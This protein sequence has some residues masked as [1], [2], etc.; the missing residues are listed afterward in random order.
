MS[1]DRA[2]RAARLFVVATG[3]LAI[4]ACWPVPPDEVPEAAIRHNTLGTSYLGQQKWPEAEAAFRQ[5]LALRPK[6]TVPLVNTAIALVQRGSSDEAR[7]LFER[8]LALDP[9]EPHAH[10]G[11]GL[12]WKNEGEFERAA[13]HFEAVER[14]DPRDVLTQYNLGS[15]L[16][17]I[18]REG[19]A[20]AHLR[21][22]LELD[23]THVFEPLCARPAAAPAQ[24]SHRGHEADRG[25]PAHPRAIGPRRSGR[26]AVRGAGTVRDGHR[27]PGGRPRG[28]SRRAGDVRA[29]RERPG[30]L[31]ASAVGPD[32]PGRPLGGR[33]RRSR[34][35]VDRAPDGNRRAT[36]AYRA[37]AGTGP[38]VGRRRQRRSGRGA[39]LLGR[40]RGSHRGPPDRR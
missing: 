18:G 22:A 10:Y 1:S 14:S 20:E 25:V 4:P 40:E 3:L 8:A 23:P 13:P 37:G 35:P 28:R 30:R 16:A 32:P 38:C 12:L 5:L 11:L 29:R 27:L 9:D 19:E 24:R 15:V 7:S 36:A 21:R 6:D 26:Y 2:W 39:R 31:D 17:R 34:H 33:R